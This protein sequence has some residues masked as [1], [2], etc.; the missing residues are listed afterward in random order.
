MGELIDRDDTEIILLALLG[1]LLSL[2]F[3]F[4][5]LRA[6]DDTIDVFLVA[7]C[8]LQQHLIEIAASWT[9]H[10]CC[11]FLCRDDILVLLGYCGILA[12]KGGDFCIT[13][14]P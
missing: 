6:T 9:C 7:C 1:L 4:L 11:D 8:I 10:Q 13:V 3:E 5:P 14:S 2:L 12:N